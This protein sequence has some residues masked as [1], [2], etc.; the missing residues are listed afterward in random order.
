[1]TA[2]KKRD[3]AM[4]IIRCTALFCVTAVHFFLNNGFYSETVAGWRMYVMVLMRTGFMV[5]VPLFMVLSGYLMLYKKPVRSYYAKLVRTVGIYLLASLFCSIYRRLDTGSISVPGEIAGLFSF[6]TASY[7]WYVEMYI[8]L[9]LLIPYL[10]IL[11]HGLD[12]RRSKQYLLLTLLLLTALPAV[13][14][15]YRFSEPQ[16]WLKPSGSTAYHPLL[17]D[18]WTGIYP[19]TYYFI[20]CYLREYPLKLKR[21]INLLLIGV[22]WLTV[23]S[24]NYYRSYG[25]SFIWGDW[26]DWGS[27]FNVIQTVLVFSYLSQRDCSQM[28]EKTIKLFA[29]L[30]KLSLGAY[31]LSEIFD[32]IFYRALNAAVPVMQ[33]RLIWFFVI[34]PAVFV[35]SLGLSAVIELLYQMAARRFALLSGWIKRISG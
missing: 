1:M 4:D 14:N 15:V 30:S 16:W 34:V 19:I 6:S 26:Q 33:D 7:S 25:W 11:Y 5:C 13:V 3:P 24:F 22:V 17:P 8:G 12:S 10:N 32:E 21:S 9:F 27:L 35:C 28:G 29:C 23:G 20:G 31:L 18:W 2:A